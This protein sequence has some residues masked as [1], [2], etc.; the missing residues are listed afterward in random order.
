LFLLIFED[1]VEFDTDPAAGGGLHNIEFWSQSAAFLTL[2][3]RLFLLVFQRLESNLAATL[4]PSENPGVPVLL[5]LCSII[6]QNGLSMT[7]F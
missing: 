6:V 1:L 4:R 3:G 5:L 2:F 7:R